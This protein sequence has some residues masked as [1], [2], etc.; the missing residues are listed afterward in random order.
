[1]SNFSTACATEHDG[2][3]QRHRLEASSCRQLLLIS[4]EALRWASMTFAGVRGSCQPRY[5]LGIVAEQKAGLPLVY[6]LPTCFHSALD[7]HG[8]DGTAHGC[9]GR[10]RQTEQV[11]QPHTSP[12]PSPSPLL[13]PAR[14][15]TLQTIT[16]SSSIHSIALVSSKTHR[17]SDT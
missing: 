10:R 8:V 11:V 16:S 4:T 12:S 2:A 5:N 13:P 14:A 1:M 15:A 7:S 3:V 17:R 9:V 6:N